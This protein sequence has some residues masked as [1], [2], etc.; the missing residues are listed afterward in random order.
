[1][2]RRC[3]PIF[4][5]LIP[6]LGGE[7]HP[8]LGGQG[9][10]SPLESQPAGAAR[11]RVRINGPDGIVQ[12]G[13]GRDRVQRGRGVICPW[14]TTPFSRARRSALPYRHSADTHPLA[15]GRQAAPVGTDRWP[16]RHCVGRRSRI[17]PVRGWG[18]ECARRRLRG[19][20]DGLSVLV[21][22]V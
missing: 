11:N 13:C 1:M 16:L 10:L 15:G 18:G 19:K 8:P 7:Y 20:P 4:I 5:S 9:S 12:T 3:S 6:L 2:V 22:E 14:S 21:T 17:R